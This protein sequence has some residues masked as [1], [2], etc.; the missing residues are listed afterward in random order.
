MIIY[1]VRVVVEPAI[2]PAYRAWLDPHIEEII[3]L[4]GFAG[5][6]LYTEADASGKPC[7]VMH[8]HVQ[9]QDALDRYF[10]EHAPRLRADGLTRFGDQFA[11]TRRVLSRHRHYAST[12]SG[13]THLQ[14]AFGPV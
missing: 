14:A 11:A 6:D 8:Y 13:Q 2:E 5:A 4:P 12:A 10:A 9:S 7:F 3:A 1:E